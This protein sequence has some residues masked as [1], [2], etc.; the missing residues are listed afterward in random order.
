MN[1]TKTCIVCGQELPLAQFPTNKRMPDGHLGWCFECF[2][3]RVYARP[4]NPEPEQLPPPIAEE[5]VPD[6]VELAKARERKRKWYQDHK[7]EAKQYALKWRKTERGRAYTKAYMAAYQKK[8]KWR[9]YK[10]EWQR[11]KRAEEKKSLKNL[12]NEK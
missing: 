1:N 5:A 3:L 11:R 7:E 10:R 9:A 8:E 6:R 2:R 12:Q 4:T